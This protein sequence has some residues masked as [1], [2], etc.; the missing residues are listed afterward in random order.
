MYCSHLAPEADVGCV[1]SIVK[2][3]R[4]FNL[5]NDI[6]G[7]LVFDGQHFCQYI[8]G[9]VGPMQALVVRIAT[10]P[11][12]CLFDVKHQAPLLG[13]R[14]F[15][16]WSMAYVFVDDVQPLAMLETLQGRAAV[17]QLEILL[18]SLDMA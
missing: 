15:T 10:D 2:T 8:E 12:H 9:P 4:S 16:N 14:K 1:S 17:S 3:A 5:A 13:P 7:I 11:R 18:P 6:T